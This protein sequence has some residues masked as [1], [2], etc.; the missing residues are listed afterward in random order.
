MNALQDAPDTASFNDGPERASLIMG[1]PDLEA[2]KRGE[3]VGSSTASPA[4]M[5]ILA[6]HCGSLIAT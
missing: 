5:T 6:S 2:D 4:S 3:G 1:M